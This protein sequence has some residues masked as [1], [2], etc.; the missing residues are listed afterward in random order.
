MT[1]CPLSG[2]GHGHVGNLYT[3]DLEKLAKASRWCTS[4]INE[5]VDGRFVDYI[6]DG[7]ARRAEYTSLLYIVRT[8][9]L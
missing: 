2:R 8:V 7:Q 9:T 1:D 3:V 4:V 6:Y 5:L